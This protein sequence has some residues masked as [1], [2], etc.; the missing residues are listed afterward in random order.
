MV[1]FLVLQPSKPRLEVFVTEGAFKGPV[2]CVKDHVFLK[3]RPAC[4]GLQANLVQKVP[5]INN[6][7]VV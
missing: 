6:T 4:E 3:M 1:F 2:L 7:L 5:E